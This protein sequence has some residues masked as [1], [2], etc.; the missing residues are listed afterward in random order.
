MITMV[1]LKS[2][3]I[4]NKTAEADF[5]PED[6]NIC[7]HVIVNLE[8][9]ELISLKEVPGYGMSYS[10]HTRQRLI[11]MAKEKDNRNECLVMWY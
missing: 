11:K 8:T 3:K 1:R 5:Y 7:G 9:G 6:S 4:G 2:I 10:G